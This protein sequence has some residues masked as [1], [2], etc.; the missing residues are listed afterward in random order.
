[1]EL[2]VPES[3]TLPHLATCY[4]NN[5][6][7]SMLASIITHMNSIRSE[8]GFKL[9]STIKAIHDLIPEQRV[10]KSRSKRSLLPFIGQFSKGLFGTATVDDVNALANHMNKLNKMSTQ[11]SK[12]L[13]QH[14]DYLSS[15]INSANERMDNLMDGIKDNSDQIKFLQNQVLVNSKTI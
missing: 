12:A 3:V 11:L 8:V 9:N 6:T 15:Y 1:M 14:E 5:S 10:H 7:C 4:E 2:E 13:S